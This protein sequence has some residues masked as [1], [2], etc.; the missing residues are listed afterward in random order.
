MEVGGS[1]HVAKGRLLAAAA[2]VLLISMGY[3][4]PGKWVSCIDSGA[5][6]GSD[7]MPFVLLFNL[8]GI[9][10]YYLSARIG[11]ITGRNLARIIG[12]A[13]GLSMMF[14]VDLFSAVLLM[15]LNAVLY[16]LFS[17]LME[18]SKFK[19]IVVYMAGLTLVCY[20]LGTL[21]SLPEFP[22]TSN[23][24]LSKLG[25]ESAFALMSLLGANI[26]PHYFY[27]HSSIVQVCE[28][29]WGGRPQLKEDGLD[30]VSHKGLKAGALVVV[31][32]TYCRVAGV[33]MS[34]L[35]TATEVGNVVVP[36]CGRRTVANFFW[37]YLLERYQ[38]PA[39]VS[40]GVWSHDNFIITLTISSG[41]F[42][43]NYVLT[44]SSASAFYNTGLG[45]LTVQ[46]SISIIDQAFRNPMVSFTSFVILFL[47]NQI[48]ALS[49][50]FCAEGGETM[51]HD[52]LKMDLPGWLHRAT[53]RIFAVVP[54]L[55]CLWH[56]G[57]EGMYHMLICI[58][59]IVALLL[60]SSMIP[61]F[62]IAS[63][64]T[65][66]GLFKISPILEFVVLLAFMGVLGLEIIFTV[67]MIF[68]ESDWV[69]NLRW[70][71]GNNTSISYVSLLSTSCIS[72]SFV[73]WLAATPLK[74]ASAGVDSQPWS[75]DPQQ[76]V[77]DSYTKM[78]GDDVVETRNHEEEPLCEQEFPLSREGYVHSHQE[79]PTAN[80]DI[81]FPDTIMDSVQEPYLST[82]EENSVV[83]V[84]A[85]LSRGHFDPKQPFVSGES[86]S[87]SNVVG[88]ASEVLPLSMS[89]VNCEAI[90]PIEQTLRI[91]GD[92]PIEKD[93]EEGNA[94]HPEESSKDAPGVDPPA[95]QEGPGSFRSL[96]GKSD[97]GG[98]SIGSLSRL[99]GLGRAARRQFAAA[100]DEFWGQLYDFHGQLTQEA[101]IKKLDLIFGMDS[102]PSQSLTKADSGLKDMGV[103]FQPLG[104]GVSVNPMNLSFKN[105]S[106]QQ[107]FGNHMNTVYKFP[108]VP[109]SIWSNQTPSLGGYGQ[110]S[111]GRM[112]DVGER[113]YQSL[114]LPPS[115][116]GLEHQ[117]ATV[118]G[119][120][121][122]SYLRPNFFNGE[123]GAP[124]QKAP[125]LVPN[126][127][128]ESPAF[129]LGQKSTN[130][131]NSMQPSSFQNLALK[132]YNLMQSDNY[133]Y[134]PRAARSVENLDSESNAKKYHSLPD[135]SGRSVSLRNPHL[136]DRSTQWS[137]PKSSMG[138]GVSVGRTAY[139][140]SSYVSVGSGTAAPVAFD[141]LSPS[142]AYKD[143]I[144]SSLN[145]A[146]NS[147]SFWSR[148]PYE[149]FGVANKIMSHGT[150]GPGSQAGSMTREP[151]ALPLAELESKLL[152]SLRICILKLLKLEGS[153]W[154]FRPND[155]VDEDLIDRVASRERFF[156]EVESQ[157]LKQAAAHLSES[158]YSYSER[159]PGTPMRGDDAVLANLVSSVPQC[160]EGCVWKADLVVSFGVWC[161]H[162]VLEL[163]LME[164]RPEL[165]GKYTYVLNRLQ[166]VIDL[167][168]FKP[169]TP[170]SPCFCLQVPASYE[171]RPS[172]PISNSSLPPAS[173]PARGKVTTAALLL[174]IIKDVEIAISCRKGRSGTAAGDVAFPK[175]KEN[176]ASVLKRYKRRLSNKP[177]GTNESG[178]G[179]RKLPSSSY[180]S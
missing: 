70:N 123:L 9:L 156:Y 18:S 43:V 19:I 15:G 21:I 95:T 140:Q 65:I 138:I 118:H 51:L 59:V 159:K 121:L 40:K 89:T 42:L 102:K 104:F 124:S 158:Q 145:S 63:S 122:A 96:G 131:L 174:D 10:C 56:S 37:V 86:I 66:M 133:H 160:G 179:S 4:D 55:Y 3:I 85:S 20:V 69:G 153:E 81:D 172:P 112:L 5:R 83:S 167:A 152:Q 176:L 38:G 139:E 92:L 149:Q 141:E 177:V 67:E 110:G 134:D 146:S 62:R 161:I 119:Y 127:Y 68:G 8:L 125:S 33:T 155:G 48:S 168:F 136:Y 79:M 49:W 45:L 54:A 29:R 93:G 90:N 32:E 98:A 64:K 101:K 61:L 71:M 173:R 73:L 164:S 120:E 114:C 128:G 147:G 7:L 23:G 132:R 31:E 171:M 157:D 109:S 47:A 129:S 107:K 24:F 178:S 108:G 94:W 154:L 99:S 26:M 36:T 12:I 165:W 169:R 57:A 13:Q 166:G 106:D 50:E 130:G 100:L 87:V 97:E 180:G 39:G 126:N 16:P 2:P 30:G 148:Q 142:R 76:I 82:I 162:R 6:F 175:G 75:W 135:I 1:N 84:P 105:A 72:L 27:L 44:N 53:V 77:H 144:A 11:V 151:E 137:I 115:S 35:W 28:K 41:I 74:S 170:M 163:S 150:E 113:R 88:G 58:Q 117:P 78:E 17:V 103:Q 14:G 143:A 60:P 80:C 46:D 22:V 25:G 111:N 116:D 91:K 52:F 34:N